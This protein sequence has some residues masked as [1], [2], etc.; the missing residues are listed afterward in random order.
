MN[1][2]ILFLLGV[3][4]SIGGV[5]SITTN[6]A[7]EFVRLGIGVHIVSFE[8]TASL[9]AMN[10]DN[11][12][13]VKALTKPV[14]SRSNIRFF[15]NYIH[16]NR[17]GIIMNQW[18]LPFY[19]TML[20]KS[21]T[22]GTDCKIIQIH[23]NNPVTNARLKQIEI[24]LENGSTKRFWGKV[25][26]HLINLASRL[27]LRYAYDNCDE[28]VF[29]S[30]T[31][32]QPFLKYI[33]VRTSS[34]VAAIPESF[35]TESDGVLPKKEKEILYLGR[36]DY[37]QK[38]VR[39]VIEIWSELEEV[40]PD[41]HLTIVGDGPDMENVKNMVVGYGLKHVS[42]EGFQK[43]DEYFKRAPIMLLVSEYE[44]FG[45]VLAEAQSYGCVPI[46]LDSYSALHDIVESGK[47][48]IIVSYP[49]VRDNFVSSI[50]LCV[51]NEKLLNQMAL[52]GMKSVDKFKMYRVLDMW[53]KLL[54]QIEKQ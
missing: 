13:D 48:G 9:D 50:K 32:I 52:N 4:P 33:W 40:L 47:N 20:I 38:R 2:E 31:F 11:R 12:V 8:Q 3:Y 7:N 39:R 53:I 43:P 21:A 27:S 16:D 46:A 29:L 44:G 37:N 23:Q 42:F 41:W 24:E 14:L 15:R 5:E 51:S 54:S 34:K 1:K 36:I 10:L 28:F 49:Y 19:T 35:S 17:I 30:Q 45:I 18:C 26:W 22:K 6:L 25:N